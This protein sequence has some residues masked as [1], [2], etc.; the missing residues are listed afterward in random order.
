ME[1]TPVCNKTIAV[2][3]DDES[4][5]TALNSLLRSSGY[6]VRT[7]RSAR[8]FLDSEAPAQ[9]GCL[10]CDIQMPGMSGIEL[11]R[12]LLRNK[13]RIP[14]LFIT[15]YPELAANTSGLVDCLPKPCDARRLLDCI[16]K[17]LGQPH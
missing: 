6:Q 14:T 4:V 8:E 9:T 16:A 17:A 11:H 2:I 15:A 5:R 7:Y 3:D 1:D 10:V 12:H 13:V